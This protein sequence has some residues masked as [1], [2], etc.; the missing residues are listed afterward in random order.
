MTSSTSKQELVKEFTV[1]GRYDKTVSEEDQ[2]SLNG[3]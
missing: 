3:M 2:V 1:P